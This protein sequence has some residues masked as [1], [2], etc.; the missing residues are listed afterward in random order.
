MTFGSKRQQPTVAAPP[1]S[2]AGIIILAVLLA[3]AAAWGVYRYVTVLRAA[4]ALDAAAMPAPGAPPFSAHASVPAP[5]PLPAAQPQP[6]EPVAPA[7]APTPVEIQ[8]PSSNAPT[9][10]QA[11]ALASPST[12]KCD[13]SIA[14]AGLKLPADFRVIAA[15]GYGGREPP[16][17]IDQSGHNATQMDVVLS[18]PGKPVALMLGAY[19]PTIWNLSWTP[20]TQLIA[21]YVGG[22]HTPRIGGLRRDIPLLT[23]SYETRRSDSGCPMF[24]LGGE[25]SLN[26]VDDAANRVFG[27]SVDKTFEVRHGGDGTIFIGANA[28]MGPKPSSGPADYRDNLVRPAGREGLLQAMQLGQVRLA[29]RDDGELWARA[30]A[31]RKG[32]AYDPASAGPPP[33]PPVN[34]YIVTGPFVY[35]SGLYGANSVIFLVPPGVPTPRGDPGHSNVYLMR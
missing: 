28:Q 20:D 12:D 10:A 19:E 34:L 13:A 9:Q 14:E 23:S 2:Q 15:G 3:A 30:M 7:P 17:P 4:T 26:S 35:P 33:T 29:R 18:S 11:P 5:V 31:Q 24:Y 8:S 25:G 32:Q 16:I 1:K 27:R 22:Y 6:V 21:V